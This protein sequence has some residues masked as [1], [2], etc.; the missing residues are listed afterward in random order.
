MDVDGIILCLST[1]TDGSP[2][3]K[4]EL[5][6]NRKLRAALGFTSTKCYRVPVAPSGVNCGEAAPPENLILLR[7]AKQS[8]R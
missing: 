8:Y 5:D 3:M 1:S 4:S 2:L 7:R 6:V